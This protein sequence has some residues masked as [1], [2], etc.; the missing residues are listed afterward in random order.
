M[1]VNPQPKRKPGVSVAALL[2]GEGP[3]AA[4]RR[5]WLVA[6]LGAGLVAVLASLLL[7][8]PA[9]SPVPERPTHFLDDQA[10][11]LS[12]A[13]AAA[14]D[15][16]IQHLSRTMRIAQIQ[17]VILPNL[18]SGD[19]EDFT[20]RAATAWK[21]GVNGADNGLLLF[22]FRD[23]RLLR[24]EVGYGLESVITD[25]Q[26]YQLLARQ[27]VPAF[28]RGQFEAGMEDFLDVLDKTLEASEA[29]SHRASPVAAMIP[30]VVNVLR[31][32]PRI[33]TQVWRTFIANDTQG[34]LV[35]SLFG[36]V[37][38]VVFVQALVGIVAGIPALLMLPWRLYSNQNLRLIRSPAV[39]D[40]FAPK[41]FFARPPPF[42][43][44]LFKDLHLGEVLNALY[45][46]AGTVVG[47]AFLF[48]GSSAL[49]GGIGHFGGAGVTL[50]WPI[51]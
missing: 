17:V 34:R 7:Q 12:P 45:L 6:L 1:I 39:R 24:L 13:F 22:V 31:S 40:Q 41:N 47:I 27:L 43:T 51:L 37:L 19:L 46:L 21:V 15:Q 35:L 5:R 42:L 9:A 28:A 33:A 10:G 36:S 23:E 8:R 4:S 30:F 49:I 11:L 44:G 3:L 25:A 18:P 48:V 16:Y 26:A 32:A 38:A 50:Q 29:S 20:I 14:K 2:R